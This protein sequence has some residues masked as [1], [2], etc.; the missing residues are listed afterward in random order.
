MIGIYKII[1]PKNKV[2]IG[3][4]TDIEKRKKLYKNL[5]CKGQIKLFNSLKKYGWENHIFEIVEECNLEQLNE[6]EYYYKKTFIKNNKW[7]NALFLMLVDG[8]GGNKNS[9]TRKKMSISSTKINTPINVYDLKGN[10]I[11][12]FNSAS[13][14]LQTMFPDSKENTGGILS[15][16]RGGKQKTF[17]NYIFQFSNNDKINIILKSLNEN[18]KI[19]QKTILQYDLNDNF[20]KQYLN[21]YQVEKEFK[22]KGIKINSTDIRACCNGKQKTC[23]NYKWKYGDSLIENISYNLD[24][25][26]LQNDINEFNKFKKDFEIEKLNRSNCKN[27]IYKFVKNIYKDEIILNYNKEIDIYLPKLNKGINIYNLK[28]ISHENSKILKILYKKYLKQNIH[29]T[30]IYSDEILNKENIVKS[31]IQNILNKTPNKIYARKCIIKEINPTLKNIFLN[32]NHIQGEDKS[33]VKL[34]LYYNDDL[35]SVMTFR[36]PRV[37]I[38]K[39]KHS[40]ENTFELIRFCNKL[41]TNILG[42]ASKLLKHFI[43]EYKPNNIF[44]FADNRWSSPLN[45]VYL[46]CGFTETNKSNVGYFY[47]KDFK[48]RLHRAN[49]TKNKLKQLGFD[50][51]KTEYEIMKLRDYHRI[52]D[53]GTTR[54][55]LNF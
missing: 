12:Q 25:N 53:C 33:L 18:V 7:T 34:G 6:R 30:Q 9:T 28:D 17:K 29:L 54:Y 20:I 49:F 11:N 10:L 31:R 19:K 4:S 41:N 5:N 32:K 38:G 45:N 48:K 44:S 35:V 37:G 13:E 26:K 40:N 47:T 2:Y 14:I 55:E 8:K 43:K 39:N 22:G 52:W 1:N 3:Q 27:I 42:A 16:C 46:K 23:K 51:N 24:K 15:S 36:Y 50:I 21:S